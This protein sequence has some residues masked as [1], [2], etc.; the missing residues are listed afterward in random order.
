MPYTKNHKAFVKKNA[1]LVAGSFEY[2][3]NPR[4]DPLLTRLQTSPS[5]KWNDTLKRM[6]PVID[7]HVP[8][9][10]KGIFKV[11]APLVYD[12]SPNIRSDD[13]PYFAN[14]DSK[15]WL[16]RWII[17][18]EVHNL[19]KSDTCKGQFYYKM[20]QDVFP[21][22]VFMATLPKQHVLGVETS[23]LRQA[24]VAPDEAPLHVKT[25]L[26]QAIN[27]GNYAIVERIETDCYAQWEHRDRGY[28]SSFL[29]QMPQFRAIPTNDN[30]Q[31]T[32]DLLRRKIRLGHR[33]YP[34]TASEVYDLH[35]LLSVRTLQSDPDDCKLQAP[36]KKPGV[37]RWHIDNRDSISKALKYTARFGIVWEFGTRYDLGLKADLCELLDR[38]IHH[39]NVTVKK[40]LYVTDDKLRHQAYVRKMWKWASKDHHRAVAHIGAFYGDETCILIMAVFNM[41]STKDLLAKWETQL[42]GLFTLAKGLGSRI[43][44]ATGVTSVIQTTISTASHLAAGA[45]AWVDQRI[46]VHAKAVADKVTAAAQP[47][48]ERVHKMMDGVGSISNAIVAAWKRFKSAVYSALSY[49]V[50]EHTTVFLV[51][52]QLLTSIISLV[53]F[54]WFIGW[55]TGITDWTIFVASMSTVVGI[56]V[57]NV[58]MFLSGA[59]PDLYIRPSPLLPKNPLHSIARRA[60]PY[61]EPAPAESFPCPASTIA[62]DVP[63]SPTLESVDEILASVDVSAFEDAPVLQAG[64]FSVGRMVDIIAG[65]LKPKANPV[66]LDYLE[67]VPRFARIGQGVE[68]FATN[69]PRIA[70]L[71]YGKV[72]GKASPTN[73]LEETIVTLHETLN[74]AMAA[75]KATG[76]WVAVGMQNPELL[77]HTSAYFDQVRDLQ[78]V[79]Y[80]KMRDI[81]PAIERLYKEMLVAATEFLGDMERYEQISHPRRASVWF[82]FCGPPGEGKSTIMTDFFRHVRYEHHKRFPSD[83]RYKLEPGVSDGDQIVRL[84][85][86]PALADPYNDSYNGQPFAGIDDFFAL[87]D[88]DLRAQQ[89]AFM[90]QIVSEA[91]MTLLCADPSKKGNRPRIDYIVTTSNEDSWD[92]TGLQTPAALYGRIGLTINVQRGPDNKMHLTLVKQP[93]HIT[94]E[95]TNLTIKG[96]L[97]VAILAKIAVDLYAKAP[98]AG[99]RDL[100]FD[101]PVEDYVLEHPRFGTVTRKG[102]DVSMAPRTRSIPSEY[103]AKPDQEYYPRFLR[104]DVGS[105]FG[106][107]VVPRFVDDDDGNHSWQA[108]RSKEILSQRAYLDAHPLAIIRPDPNLTGPIYYDQFEGRYYILKTGQSWDKSYGPW[109]DKSPHFRGY[110]MPQALGDSQQEL[111]PDL[112][113]MKFSE[114]LTWLTAPRGLCRAAFEEYW[115]LFPMYSEQA[116]PD[117]FAQAFRS[118]LVNLPSPGLRVPRLFMKNEIRAQYAII[119][120]TCVNSSLETRRYLADRS[121]RS[122]KAAEST[123]RFMAMTVTGGTP[124][125]SATD[126]PSPTFAASPTQ[127]DDDFN[128]KHFVVGVVSLVVMAGLLGGVIFGAYRLALCIFPAKSKEELEAQLQSGEPRSSRHA[129]PTTRTRPANSAMKLVSAKPHPAMQADWVEWEKSAGNLVKANFNGINGWILFLKGT[130]AVANSHSFAK[131]CPGGTL[132][133]NI[134]GCGPQIDVAHED[135]KIYDI[136]GSASSIE[137]VLAHNPL[138]FFSLDHRMNYFPDITRQFTDDRTDDVTLYRIERHVKDSS[139]GPKVLWHLN[140]S[141]HVT[142]EK[143]VHD[144]DFKCFSME[145]S[146]GDCGLPYLTRKPFAIIGIHQAGIDSGNV[147][148]GCNIT[149]KMVQAVDA[150]YSQQE[151]ALVIHEARVGI[152]PFQRVMEWQPFCPGTIPLGRLKENI[153][154]IGTTSRLR[155]THLHPAKICLED[156]QGKISLDFVPTRMP[157]KLSITGA[158]GYPTPNLGMVLGK[159]SQVG[160]TPNLLPVFDWAGLWSIDYS[161]FVHKSFTA[162]G[163]KDLSVH[164]AIFGR[165]GQHRA[166]DWGTSPGA[167][168]VAQGLRRP[169]VILQSAEIV[170]PAFVADVQK[171]LDG[172]ERGVDQSFVIDSP[173]DEL[174]PIADAED[175]KIR[176]FAIM[177][178][179]RVVAGRCVFDAAIRRLVATPCFSTCAIGINPHSGDWTALGLRLAKHQHRIIAGDFKGHEFTLPQPWKIAWDLYF[180]VLFSET[181]PNIQRRR[182]NCGTSLLYPVH[183]LGQYL[184]TT[185]R[186]GGSG[187]G[188]TAIYAYFISKMFHVTAWLVLYHNLDSFFDQVEL[189]IMGDDSIGGVSEKAPEFNM[190]YLARFAPSIGMVYTSAVKKDISVPYLEL[191]DKSTEFLKRSFSWDG[192]YYLAPLRYSSIMESLMWQDKSATVED[193]CNTMRS[194]MI[195]MRHYGKSEY[196]R[197]FILLNRYAKAQGIHPKLPPT[198]QAMWMFYQDLAGLSQP[199]LELGEGLNSTTD[200]DSL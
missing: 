164:E 109:S 198:R 150:L 108:R 107:Y 29:R 6:V 90:L 125:Q 20:A 174:L 53:C 62:A 154:H 159:Y 74:P 192:T 25:V 92:N 144:T 200:C 66:A 2:T 48:Q 188:I 175:N 162:Q 191:H 145:N 81:Q 135:V 4:V 5:E 8:S 169:D 96:E 118:M 126:E 99:H 34:L 44:D 82:A 160:G 166:I 152:Q 151:D 23:E 113:Y 199:D 182:E 133:L 86:A 75:R 163:V 103:L 168:H 190:L 104:G 54:I 38:Y 129:R 32:Q 31:R 170:R 28:L 165:Q 110:P 114:A 27:E 185:M 11:K 178:I 89:G 194:V 63:E 102:D 65:I 189:S 132:Q 30:V 67:L 183:I 123:L 180:Q 196:E 72:T 3:R 10:F 14:P 187:H 140:H 41:K 179:T 22:D 142:Y 39:F 146:P 127:A 42:Q 134:D 73:P 106:Q 64:G 161:K 120:C 60:I 143:G 111:M 193:R 117:E 98:V 155:E 105:G 139:K 19:F 136:T 148:Y 119:A 46:S 47:T 84:I 186:R 176:L 9:T 24:F 128:K 184:Y 55:V 80:M 181:P 71:V 95:P 121:T 197:M 153:V 88:P 58:A 70:I 93:Q 15:A 195:E 13:D 97:T 26:M 51:I 79:I 50:S 122:D 16:H 18:R 115:P 100:N 94:V 59:W 131:M 49:Q 101:A 7:S 40:D 17:A 167:P 157:A 173:K 45:T 177:E 137:D 87:K 124:P 83:P 156:D 77:Q 61:E 12:T 149:K 43:M 158:N 116:T 36:V 33:A 91:P 147:S 35:D 52:V 112:L 172:W 171:T 141:D 130:L 68:W 1:I 85:Y 37:V 57:L 76:S 78:H 69:I 138:V 56:T 21:M